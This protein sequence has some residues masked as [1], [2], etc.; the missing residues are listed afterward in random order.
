MEDYDKYLKYKKKYLELKDRLRSRMTGGANGVFPLEDEIFFWSRQMMEHL[1]LLWLGL[2]DP[3]LELKKEAF[4]LS[5]EWTNYLKKNFVEKGIELK[6]DLVVLTPENLQLVGQLD[7]A[8]VVA[9]IDKTQKYQDKLLSVLGKNEWIGW[10][11]PSLALHMQSE[12]IYFRRKVAGPAFVPEEEVAFIN[13]H[14]KEET[15][16]TAHLLDPADEN[17]PLVQKLHAYAAKTMPEWSEMDKKVL[18]GMDI[19]EQ[20]TLLKLSIKYSQELTAMAEELGMKIDAKQIK[21]IISPVLAH[22]I[23]REFNRFTLTLKA[24]GGQA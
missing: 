18:Q 9:M 8:P 2:E 16:T 11:F 17:I 4:E 20:A 6:P 19:T 1:Q 15:N 10:I 22:H 3:R 7:P 14:H 12:T 21:S 23:G 5:K 13:N 24:L